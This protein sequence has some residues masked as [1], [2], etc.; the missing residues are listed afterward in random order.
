MKTS[1]RKCREFVINRQ[2]F[3]GS[4]LYG[5]WLNNCY[6]VYSYGRHFPIY[7][8]RDGV[9]YANRGKYSQSTTRHQSQARPLHQGDLMEWRDTEGLNK[10][11]YQ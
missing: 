6:T 1:N 9:W 3:T 8:W 4:N 11:I 2:A 10:I 5:E 7:V